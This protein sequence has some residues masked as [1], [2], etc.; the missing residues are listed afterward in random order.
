MERKRKRVNTERRRKSPT[1]GR[2][3]SVNEILA[4][5]YEVDDGK[6]GVRTRRFGILPHEFARDSCCLI[7]GDWG[8]NTRILAGIVEAAN[9][10]FQPV[11]SLLERAQQ[12]GDCRTQHD[13][14]IVNR[15]IRFRGGHKPSANVDYRF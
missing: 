11:S 4:W 2:R 6:F 8:R 13:A 12:V 3:T 10:V 1:R 7:E 9:M 14:E 5:R 15:N